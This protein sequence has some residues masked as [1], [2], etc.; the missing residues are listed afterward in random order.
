MT[1]KERIKQLCKEHGVSMNKVENDLSFGKGYISKL[2][3]STPNVTK[4]QQI[5][6]YFGVGLDFLLTGE[7]KAENVNKITAKDEK[8][9]AK[10]MENIRNKLLNGTD[11]PISYDGEPI[12]EE[13]AELLLGQIELMM[14]RLKPINKEKYNPNKNKSR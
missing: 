7:E 13:D 1:L 11:G 2:G 10:D 14:R 12:P 4:I 5:A 6:D 9:I 8:D 3:T